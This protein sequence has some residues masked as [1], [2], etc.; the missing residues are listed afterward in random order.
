MEETELNMNEIKA[1]P[2]PENYTPPP[3]PP[4]EPE[5][6]KTQSQQVTEDL[7]N[8]KDDAV[9]ADEQGNKLALA[10]FSGP[11]TSNNANGSWEAFPSNGETEVTSAWQTP[12]AETGKADWELAL[13]E[14]ASNLSKQKAALA[15]GFDR[16]MS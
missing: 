8:L 11:P 13:V 2:A 15:G 12:A 14:S 4:P 3:P 6:P 7:V 5:Q 16:S 10:L 9:S 1:L